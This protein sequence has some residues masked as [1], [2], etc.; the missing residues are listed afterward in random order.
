M[1][2]FDK[3]PSLLI[4]D[5]HDCLPLPGIEGSGGEHG[6]GDGTA[7]GSEIFEQA[8]RQWDGGGRTRCR[9]AQALIHAWRVGANGLER[10]CDVRTVG[11]GSGA[12][13]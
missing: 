8:E 12:R 2:G 13:D 5:V 7:V 9:G 4:G 6:C 11:V 10:L 3:T 1:E